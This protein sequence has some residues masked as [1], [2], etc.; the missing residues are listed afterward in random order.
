MLNLSKEGIKPGLWLLP[1]VYYWNGMG[2][3][4][5]TKRAKIQ[6]PNASTTTSPL[7]L[8][9]FLIQLKDFFLFRLFPREAQAKAKT[10]PIL[11]LHPYLAQ[12]KGF[13]QWVVFSTDSFSVYDIISF[14][15]HAS[16]HSPTATT[17]TTPTATPLHHQAQ[18]NNGRE[19]EVAV[20][21]V[22]AY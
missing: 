18:E 11:L 4:E 13:I 22:L 2:M 5:K 8:Y 15:S 17:S 3:G 9:V 14:S 6:L 16:F 21:V 1:T 20:A 19:V 7:L 12:P 10:I